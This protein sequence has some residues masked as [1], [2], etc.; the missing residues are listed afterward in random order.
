M[1]LQMALFHSFYGWVVLHCI[2]VPHLFDP[3]ICRW[4]FSLFPCLGQCKQCCN[5]HW[6]ACIFLN[7]GFLWVYAQEWGCWIIMTT[8]FLDF[9]LIKKC[10]YLD[11]LGLSC[12]MQAVLCGTGFSLVV[13]SGLQSS[14]ALQLWLMGLAV[15]QHVGPQFPDQGWNPCLLQWKADS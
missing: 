2:Y 8:R 6:D 3:F 12:G 14:W 1:L 7:Y 11:A 5:E 10:I 15:P 9:F 4:T 13:G